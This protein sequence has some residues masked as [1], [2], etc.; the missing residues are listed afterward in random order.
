M[1]KFLKQT[2]VRVAFLYGLVAA[3]WLPPLSNRFLE[4][5]FNIHDNIQIYKGWALVAGTAVLFYLILRRYEQ[6]GRP[7]ETKFRTILESLLPGVLIH[8]QQQPLFVNRAFANLFGYSKADEILEMKTVLPLVVSEDYGSIAASHLALERGQP[9]PRY[10][11]RGLRRD[12]SRCGVA[13]Q[14]TVIEWEGAP[15]VL[16]THIDVTDLKQAEEMAARYRLLAEQTQEI[17]LFISE[18]GSIVDANN[19]AMIAYGYDRDTLLTLTINNLHASEMVHEVNSQLAKAT[20]HGVRFE[21]MHRR[22]NGSIFPVEVTSTGGELRGQRLLLSVVRDITARQ[23]HE[24]SLMVRE[25]QQKAIADLSQFA[26]GTSDVDSLISEA[27]LLLADILHV[28]YSTVLKLLPAGEELL[29]MAG[30]G[31]KEGM[32]GTATVGSGENSQASYTLAADGPL[33]VNDLGTETRFTGAPFL[34][35]QG[36]VSGMTVTIRQNEKPWGILGAHTVTQREFT[37]DDKDFL[38]AAAK[39]LSM[40]LDRKAAGDK[41]TQ[42]ATAVEQSGDSIVITDTMGNI[43]YVNP[44]FEQT[45]GY[46]TQEVMGKNSRILKSGKSSPAFYNEL[47]ETITAGQEWTGHLSNK[48]KDG[49]LYE[50]EAMISPVR[51]DTGKIIAYVAVK[52]DITERMWADEQM[53]Q[54]ARLLDLAP[55][56]VRDMKHRIGFWSKGLEQLYGYTSEEAMGRPVD[57]LLWTEL[58]VPLTEIEETLQ[59]KGMWEGEVVRRTRDGSHITVTSRWLLHRDVHGTPLRILEVDADITQRRE[60]EEEIKK[61]NVGL[62]QRVA[63]RTAELRDAKEQAEV[64]S[65]AKSDFLANM[66]HE[67]RTPLNAIIG[68]SELLVDQKFG[69]LNP[70]QCDSMN[71]ILTSGRHL[72]D[73]ITDILDLTK[74]TAGKLELRPEPFSISAAMAQACIVVKDIAQQKKIKIDIEKDLDGD[75]VCLDPLRFKQILYN[76]VSNAVKYTPDN[77]AVKIQIQKNGH[78]Q[79]RLQVSD[80]GIG[81]TKEDLPRL[82]CEFE[83]IDSSLAKRAQGTGLGLALT[84]KIVEL[85][86]GSISVESEVGMGSTFTVILPV[87]P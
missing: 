40:A 65:R 60:I 19:A 7:G 16:S 30:A 25:G 50:E 63:Q 83:Q 34:L 84:K 56:L 42:L 82:F 36:V 38:T 35:E 29:L 52:R 76:L 8:R 32:V 54:Q 44:R 71:D 17:I 81:I 77:G 24:R 26:L 37:S 1:Q 22:A 49:S 72:L 78:K 87:S 12:G 9:V 5:L 61:W 68:F 41:V 48:K 80:T 57:E 69:A 21:S 18:N 74:I 43:Q 45:T 51:D 62:E 70:D 39:V 73:L 86:K 23:Q 11:Y 6:A 55:V 33:V 79:V 53:R 31:W 20:P 58:P 66:S 67:L 14:A 59:R 3:L 15:A 47:W 13:A 75:E 85:Q 46:S 28:E 10:E 27:C 2:A 4:G 64:A